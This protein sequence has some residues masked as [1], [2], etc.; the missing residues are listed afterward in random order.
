MRCDRALSSLATGGPFHRWQAQRHAARC[1][2]VRA[3]SRACTHFK[4]LSGVRRAFDIHSAVFVGINR[5]HATLLNPDRHGA[6]PRAR[7]GNF[8]GV[9]MLI[10]LAIL[11][12]R[13]SPP[14]TER[15]SVPVVNAPIARRQ[16]SPDVIQ[17][18]DILKSKFQALSQELAQLR[19]RAELLDERRDAESLWRRFERPLALNGP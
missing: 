8:D 5:Y 3:N 14:P 11:V 2:Y 15:L 10:G 18:L 4:E 16:V 9:V 17:D 7:C 1:L 13:P 12:L 19:R 6:S